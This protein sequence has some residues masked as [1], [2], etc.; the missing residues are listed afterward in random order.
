M[1]HEFEIDGKRVVAEAQWIGG[2]LW[3]HLNG[4]TFIHEDGAPGARK[5][6]K[7]GSGQAG[8]LVAPMPGRITKI[9]GR[10]GEDV[11]KG[12]PVLV[13]EA[14]KMEYTL[15]SEG[16]GTIESLQCQVGDQVT[17]GKVLVKIKPSET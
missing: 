15:K 4:K 3:L 12:D 1:R 7:G 17:L 8:D 6:S 5:R 14:M 10:V 2:R 9:F 13:M 11:I 16:P